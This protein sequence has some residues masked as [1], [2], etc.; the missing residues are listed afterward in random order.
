[1]GMMADLGEIKSDVKANNIKIDGL[2]NKV[3][4]LEKKKKTVEERNEKQF[5]DLREEVANVENRVT[6]KLMAE[7][8]PA[9]EGMRK[10]VQSSATQ[11]IRRIVQEEVEL[12]RLREA[13]E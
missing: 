10:E 8:T 4:E 1:M 7:I 3:D 12:L 6:T 13:K 9:L 11:D 5:T 2:T